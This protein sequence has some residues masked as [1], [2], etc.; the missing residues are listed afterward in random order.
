MCREI[1]L[2]FQGRTVF[3]ERNS[4]LPHGNRQTGQLTRTVSTLETATS[5]VRMM[6]E[7]LTSRRGVYLNPRSSVSHPTA[8]NR[9][10]K[11]AGKLREKLHP[12]EAD[13][14]SSL[15]LFNALCRLISQIRKHSVPTLGV[16]SSLKGQLR[17]EMRTFEKGQ[18]GEG[19]Q[20]LSS[21]CGSRH[22]AES[23]NMQ[24]HVSQSPVDILF[25]RSINASC[26]VQPFTR[27]ILDCEARVVSVG[28]SS[29]LDWSAGLSCSSL[30]WPLQDVVL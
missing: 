19:G 8:P 24:S 5:Y 6:R 14:C 3:W 21:A 17:V 16:V 15:V 23:R 11:A 20:A 30:R 28:D 4:A 22:F 10:W 9:R 18:R 13:F 27:G 2:Q 26:I 29:C 12:G 7:L 25:L 1:L